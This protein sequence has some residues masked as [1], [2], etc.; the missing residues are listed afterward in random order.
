MAMVRYTPETLP[1][2]TEKDWAR[3]DSIKDQDIDFS[4]IP[5]ITDLSTF[6]PWS[7][8]KDRHLYKPVKA[9]VNCTLDADVV[10]W[11]KRDGRGYQTRMNAILRKVMLSS[12]AASN[13][14]Q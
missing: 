6:H 8:W 4:D 3:V 12:L 7:E 1:E 14:P 10:A 5:E 11:L 9:K 13:P 2:P